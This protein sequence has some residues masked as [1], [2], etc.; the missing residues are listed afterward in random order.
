MKT[1]WNTCTLV[2]FL[3]SSTYTFLPG[4][5]IAKYAELFAPRGWKHILNTW[6]EKEKC[7]YI[8]THVFYISLCVVDLAQGL[9]TTAVCRRQKLQ[10]KLLWSGADFTDTGRW[11]GEEPRASWRFSENWEVTLHQYKD[12]LS[13]AETGRINAETT[14]CLCTSQCAAI[15]GKGEGDYRWKYAWNVVSL[16]LGGSEQLWWL[17]FHFYS[18]INAALSSKRNCGP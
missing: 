4:F 5:F 12:D 16:E 8:S 7:W 11:R 1:S 18:L 9:G 14:S 3:F 6:K 17:H 2:H 15:R 10:S 13:H